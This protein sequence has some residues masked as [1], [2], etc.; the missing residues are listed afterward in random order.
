M[1]TDSVVVGIVSVEATGRRRH[2]ASWRVGIH[3]WS[4]ETHRVG[5]ARVRVR[6]SGEAVI[7]CVVQ[8][9]VFHWGRQIVLGTHF[10]S[11]I[12]R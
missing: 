8:K 1:G 6:V 4:G 3:H 9:A 12:D 11:K 7:S 5:A 10:F 2:N